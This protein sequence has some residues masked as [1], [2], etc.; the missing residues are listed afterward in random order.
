MRLILV[1]QDFPPDVGGTQTYSFEVANWL[2][3]WCEDFV[4]VAPKVPGCEAIDAIL[5]YEVIRLECSYNQLGFKTGKTLVNLAYERGFDS[6]FHVQWSTIISGVYAR[7]RSPIKYIYAAAHGRELLLRPLPFFNS[8]Y[9]AFR[10]ILLQKADLHF[11]VSHYTGS[12]LTELGISEA[13]IE[14]VPNGVNIDRFYPVNVDLEKSKL[15]LEDKKVILT[16]CRLVERKG[17]DVV[18]NALP[19]LARKIPEIKYLIAGTGP[20]LQRLQRLAEQL[21]V[22]DYISFLGY[23]PDE[24]L[25]E[26]YNLCDVFVMP[27][28]HRPPEV[29]G[30]GLV[31][32]EA[33]ATG[34]PCLGTT[35]GGIS[36]AIQDGQTG[37]LVQPNDYQ[38]LTDALTR[39]LKDEDL[40]SRM[41]DNA[42]FYIMNQCNWE[43]RVKHIYTTLSQRRCISDWKVSMNALLLKKQKS[44]T[45]EQE[46]LAQQRYRITI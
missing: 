36:D 39:L 15:G 23:I 32:L 1:T 3:K 16:V 41:G 43:E 14:V 7:S 13:S 6:V 22:S 17:I 2:A 42:R 4:I 29:E 28:H 33:G 46:S 31:F 24:Q 25:N 18:I 20:D 30:F 44:A 8:W 26:I 34:K 11:P 12:L 45:I 40:A 21:G 37:Y 35:A 27:S 10:K 5:P 9:N 38:G 19:E